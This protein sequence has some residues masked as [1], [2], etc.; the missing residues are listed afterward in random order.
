MYLLVGLRSAWKCVEVSLKD[1]SV[2]VI[3]G[4][5]LPNCNIEPAVWFKVGLTVR[6]VSNRSAC[7]FVSAGSS[8]RLRLYR[9]YRA[10]DIVDC[11]EAQL[12]TA[13]LLSSSCAD[14]SEG[15]GPS[16][17]QGQP[18]LTL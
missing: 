1:G 5:A 6:A 3:G 14:G 13:S 16:N 7:G 2:P 9:L 11:G 12:Y 8:A 4:V 15:R 18:P 10:R 17:L